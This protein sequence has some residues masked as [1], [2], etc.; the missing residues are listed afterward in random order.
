MNMAK[1][2]ERLCPALCV[3]EDNGKLYL[4]AHFKDS[5]QTCPPTSI[6]REAPE[7]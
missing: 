1:D 4:P 7:R 2:N 5:K 3:I 6:L